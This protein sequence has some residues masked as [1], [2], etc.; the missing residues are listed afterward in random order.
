MKRLSR[1]VVC[2]VSAAVLAGGSQSQIAWAEE[3]A[4]VVGAE[5]SVAVPLAGTRK[6]ADVGGAASVFGGYHFQFND[7]IGLSLLAQPEFT[8]FPS[9]H[10]RNPSSGRN[11]DSDVVAIMALNAG[12]RLTIGGPAAR[13]FIDGRGGYYR[14]LSGPLNDDGPGYNV[15]GGAAFEIAE[16]TALTVGSRYNESF[17]RAKRGSHENLRFVTAGLGIEHYFR[18]PAAVAPAPPPPP[19]PPPP[20]APMKKK[21]ILRGVN[22]DFDKSNIRADARPVLDEA[23]KTLKEYGNVRVS[24]EGHTDSRGTEA[25]NQALSVRRASS[26]AA[27]LQSGGIARSRLEVSGFGESRPVASNDT[28]DG[29]AQNRRVELNVVP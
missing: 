18:A 21:M 9:D 19:P 10:P 16:N 29:R 8:F 24:V 20:A 17:M 6:T 25:Y 7:I 2:W 11:S 22:F 5:L 28:D 3:G 15:G 23:I 26:V 27:Y 12:P 13:V 4:P 14:D 1:V